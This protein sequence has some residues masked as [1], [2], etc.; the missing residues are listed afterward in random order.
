MEC[1]KCKTDIALSW[2]RYFSNPLGRFI[3]PACQ[4]KFK[5]I[6]PV[7]WYFFLFTWIAIYFGSLMLAVRYFGFHYIWEFYF[8]LTMILLT[9][10]FVIDRKLESSYKTQLCRRR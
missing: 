3:C 8:T 2:R 4:S 7:T 1:P 5:F 9:V 6:R 10:Y